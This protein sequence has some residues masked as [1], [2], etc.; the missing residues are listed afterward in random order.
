VDLKSLFSRVCRE[1]YVPIA[2]AGGWSDLNLRAE[3]I[4]RFAR[5]DNAGKRCVLLYCGDH[6]PG[7]LNISNTLRSNLQDLAGAV[8]WSP[9]NLVIDRFG[10]NADFIEAQGLTWIDNLAT[11]Q[12]KFTLS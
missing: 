12:G 8:G 3:L 5:W 9:A 10:L 6:D 2:D 4:E 11:A 7:G 1:L